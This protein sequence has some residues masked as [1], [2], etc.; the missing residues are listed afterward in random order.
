MC[1]TEDLKYRQ[2]FDNCGTRIEFSSAFLPDLKHRQMLDNC[3]T[4]IDFSSAAFKLRTKKQHESRTSRII[5]YLGTAV[6]QVWNVPWYIQ[7]GV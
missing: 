2:M 4:R 6:R 7:D 5:A 1:N 3:G